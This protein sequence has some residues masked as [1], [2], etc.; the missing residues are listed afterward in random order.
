MGTVKG[1]W[2]SWLSLVHWCKSNDKERWSDLL[3]DIYA[4]YA[5]G[6]DSTR[7]GV[8]MFEGWREDAVEKFLNG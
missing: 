4:T 3:R 7:D 2:V 8:Y 6:E 1:E 5:R